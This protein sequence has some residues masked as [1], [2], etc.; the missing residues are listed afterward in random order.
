MIVSI[1]QS[2]K[3]ATYQ[4]YII[5]LGSGMPAGSIGNWTAP[6]NCETW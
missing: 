2:S 1:E 6:R 3:S 4:F 5:E